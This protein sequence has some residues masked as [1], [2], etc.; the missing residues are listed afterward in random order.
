MKQITY[1]FFIFSVF[2]PTYLFASPV[3]KLIASEILNI[4][5]PPKCNSETCR[6]KFKKIIKF[7][8]YGNPTAQMLVATAYLTGDG[9]EQNF[10]LSAK[11]LRKAVR[12]GSVKAIWMLSNLYKD[13]IGVEQSTTKAENLLSRAVKKEYGPALFQKAMQTFRLENANNDSEIELLKRAKIAN[14]KPAIYLLAKMYETGSAIE[15]DYYKS[16]LLY[17]ELEFSNY[18][19]SQKRLNLVKE[20]AKKAS[21]SIY[22]KITALDDG[23]EVI[24]INHQ[25]FDYD[26]HLNYVINSFRDERSIYDGRGGMSHIQGRACGYTSGCR[27][28]S[29]KI[30]IA[31]FFGQKR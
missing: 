13:G 30:D 18:K 9:L 3:Q 19:D 25:R 5:S 20:T 6:A 28:K 14:F 15:Q 11:W 26:M 4:D 8:R 31:T 29:Q 21:P 7:A 10:K 24:T 17:K 23:T 12:H 1:Y 2:L 16:A 22:E 27:T